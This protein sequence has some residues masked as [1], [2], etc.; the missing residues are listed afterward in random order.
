MILG[1]RTAIYPAPDLLHGRADPPASD[2]GCFYA[3]S[4][5]GVY[6]SHRATAWHVVAEPGCCPGAGPAFAVPPLPEHESIAQFPGAERFPYGDAME[7]RFADRAVDQLGPATART[8]CHIPPL[9]DAPLTRRRR[10]QIFRTPGNGN[11]RD[12]IL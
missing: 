4:A 7:W 9:R 2:T 1:L 11:A 5:P 3:R 12:R 8:R 6:A 10:I